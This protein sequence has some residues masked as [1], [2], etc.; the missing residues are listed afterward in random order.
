METNEERTRQLSRLYHDNIDF[1]KAAELMRGQNVSFEFVKDIYAKL[2]EQTEKS[3][4]IY[5]IIV[6]TVGRADI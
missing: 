4:K 6:L 2:S 3:K 5:K 1:E